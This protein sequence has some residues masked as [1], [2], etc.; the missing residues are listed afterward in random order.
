MLSVKNLVPLAQHKGPVLQL[1]KQEQTII[2]KLNKQLRRC[3][4]QIEKY[5]SEIN[6]P[7]VPDYTKGVCRRKI[8]DMRKEMEYISTEIRNIKINRYEKQKLDYVV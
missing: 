5:Q 4:Y 6:T 3:S 2:R 8:D 7:W 1:T